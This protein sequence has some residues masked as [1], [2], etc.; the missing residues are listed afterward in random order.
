MKTTL[1]AL[2][3]LLLTIGLGT[4]FATTT[5]QLELSV[6]G[7]TAT[8]VDN[9]VG[10][11]GTGCSGLS[12]D[13]NS[14]AGELVVLGT[15]GGWDI[16][17]TTGKSYSPNDIPV[18]LDLASLTATCAAG[19]ACDNETLSISYSDINFVAD[20]LGYGTDYSATIAG[21]GSTSQSA[22]WDGSNTIFG[23]ANLIGTVGPF[24]TTNH[25]SAFSAG[26]S[27][28][29]N[30]LTLEQAFTAVGTSGVSFSVDGDVYSTPEPGAIILLGTVLVFCA[31]K[32]RRRRAS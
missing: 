16:S 7:L 23:T 10:C 3:A 15:I 29:P 28:A 26:S 31:S 25:G 6:S 11:T 19:A 32:L 18:G 1:L 8:F 27:T 21:S 14:A 13:L 5:D 17:V 24:I 30:S 2:L 12:G 20:P 4:T 22:Y 9:V